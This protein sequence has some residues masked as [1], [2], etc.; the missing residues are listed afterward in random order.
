MQQDALLAYF[1]FAAMIGMGAMLAAGFAALKHRDA[2]N[3]LRRLKRLDGMYGLFALLTLAS[4]VARL[5][6]GA[7]GSAFYL[8]NPVFHTKISLFVLAGLLSIY[9]TV[10]YFKW[11]DAI[12]ADSRFRPPA[13]KV[14]RVRMLIV[15]QFVLLAAIPLAA[16]LMARG[17]GAN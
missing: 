10:Q 6:F 4:G 12:H 1:H 2:A 16:S 11:A 14:A 7:K 15:I 13:D 3:D 9:P 8:S 5:L 17:I